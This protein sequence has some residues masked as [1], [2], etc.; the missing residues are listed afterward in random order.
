MC[1]YRRNFYRATPFYSFALL[2]H[3][4]RMGSKATRTSKSNQIHPNDDI[5]NEDPD[6]YGAQIYQDS[7][8]YSSVRHGP[9]PLYVATGVPVN[10]TYPTYDY[11]TKIS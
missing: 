11:V 9:A 2:N 10:P 1:H 8:P 4:D 7:R 6:M 3:I 5:E